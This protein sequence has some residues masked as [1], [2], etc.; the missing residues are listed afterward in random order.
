MSTEN[1][2]LFPRQDKR[3]SNGG[4]YLEMQ[5][6]SCTVKSALVFNKVKNIEHNICSENLLSHRH[7]YNVPAVTFY[8][9]LFYFRQAIPLCIIKF[10]QYIVHLQYTTYIKQDAIITI[11]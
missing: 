8:F 10:V 7:S 4:D 1:I 3:L 5:W 2:Q 9:I 6:D 11:R